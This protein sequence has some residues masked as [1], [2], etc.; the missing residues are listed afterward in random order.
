MTTSTNFESTAA[1]SSTPVFQVDRGFT[2]QNKLQFEAMLSEPE[3]VNNMMFNSNKY[4]S[5]ANWLLFPKEKVTGT[6]SKNI[7]ITIHV[8]LVN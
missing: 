1:N 2:L 7:N 5:Y 8:Y 4:R 6:T 3:H